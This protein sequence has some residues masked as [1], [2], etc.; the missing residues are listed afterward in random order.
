MF[1]SCS[2]I[3]ISATA[4]HKRLGFKGL[5]V[6]AS[7]LTALLSSAVWAEACTYREALMALEQG[8]TGRGLALMRMA[9]RDGDRRAEAYLVQR[10]LPLTAD[11]SDEQPLA[12]LLSAWRVA[13]TVGR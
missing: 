12:R 1:S 2:S 5:G 10:D 11:G 3:N 13:D 6:A 4:S 7:L 9:R 8:N